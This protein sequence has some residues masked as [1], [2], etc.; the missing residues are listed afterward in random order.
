[1]ND[2]VK[3]ATENSP[4]LGELQEL[5]KQGI[6]VFA[7]GTC[8]ARLGLTDKLAA[9]KISNMDEIAGKMLNAGKVISL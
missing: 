1:M 8:L 5:E 3:L 6:E 4:S 9:G 2:G 7:C